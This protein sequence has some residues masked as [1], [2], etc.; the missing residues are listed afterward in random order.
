MIFEIKSVVC[1]VGP[2]HMEGSSI[3]GEEERSSVD[4]GS[5]SHYSHKQWDD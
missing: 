1:I 3:I 5:V 2:G 4:S